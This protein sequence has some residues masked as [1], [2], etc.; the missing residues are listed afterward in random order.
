[1]AHNE[2]EE[3]KSFKFLRTRSINKDTAHT[4]APHLHAAKNM[5][6]P[7]HRST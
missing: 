2:K 4:L 7:A 1:M 6:I 3:E 5:L